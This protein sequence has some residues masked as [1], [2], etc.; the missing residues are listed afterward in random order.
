MRI[1]YCTIFFWILSVTA[2]AQGLPDKEFVLTVIDKTNGYWQAH[3]NPLTRAFWNHATYHT[4]NMEVLR[5]TGNGAYRKY[6][7]KWAEYNNWIGT[8]S[9]DKTKWKYT[10]GET[11]Q[12]HNETLLQ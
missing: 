3:N 8:K 9:T 5:I 7:E 12:K 11:D 10:Y 6:S 2:I 1:I 4:G